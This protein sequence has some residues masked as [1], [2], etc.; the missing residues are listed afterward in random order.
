[1]YPK[2]L[3][4]STF[5]PF[6]QIS[7]PIWL[8]LIAAFVN[9]GTSAATL[10]IALYLTTQMHFTAL[11]VGWVISSI[12]IGAI[13][14][15]LSSGWLSDNFSPRY[16][17]ITALIVNGITLLIIPNLESFLWII[18]ITTCIG[19]SN[20]AFTPANRVNIMGMTTY[21][22]QSKIS[23]IRYMLI[24]LGIGIYILIDGRLSAF[25]YSQV[26]LFNGIVILLMSTALF[27]SSGKH[28]LK[29]KQITPQNEP[30]LFSSHH[31][32]NKLFFLSTYTG[33][34]FVALIFSQLRTT[35]PLYLNTFYHLDAD[36][37]S[38]LFIIN[39]LMIVLF[40]MIILNFL[41]RFNP[42]LIA[43]IGT[44]FIGL[45]VG[46]IFL[47]SS[48]I[49]ALFLCSVWTLGEILF[50]ST[51]QV[52]I[53]NHAHKNNK[54]KHMGAYQS[55]IALGNVFGPITGGWMYSY[56]KGTILWYS[57]I[58]LG[59]FSLSIYVNLIRLSK[60]NQ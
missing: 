19:I 24:N 58:L 59:I 20:F 51:I 5:N 54:G 3:L 15:S 39:T 29:T 55:V 42:I 22:D 12:G 25:G 4:E 45:G 38:S 36:L 60:N 52:V 14:G 11:Q 10:F 9:A 56:N 33:I 8:E 21:A 41:S 18:T 17:S 7:A 40:Q 44:F 50:F 43:G 57:C 46:L 32:G 27:I 47:G 37:F 34:L 49:F 1:M 6:K 53:Y 35:Y 28:P 26:F 48:Y 23:G 13:F 30:S 31:Q 2:K 16:I